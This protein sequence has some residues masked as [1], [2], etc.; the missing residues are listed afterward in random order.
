MPCDQCR[1]PVAHARTLTKDGRRGRL[2]RREVYILHMAASPGGE[3]VVIPSEGSS[4]ADR[5]GH[6]RAIRELVNVGL[7]KVQRK[8]I[9]VTTKTIAATHSGY[10]T[11]P[12]RQVERRYR[13]SAVVRTA[14]GQAIVDLLGDLRTP[15]KVIRWKE[16]R[17][18]LSARVQASPSSVR[19]EFLRRLQH[20]IEA[21][22]YFGMGGPL[23]PSAITKRDAAAALLHLRNQHPPW[24]RLGIA[25][26]T[27]PRS[28]VVA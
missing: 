4:R 2:G 9:D 8:K 1:E 14:L 21:C 20:H 26:A 7:V 16:Y 27:D 12:G 15:A 11:W 22:H 24:S 23:L 28:N 25:H 18:A 19:A 5:E 13:V 6:R 10:R 17:D 3:P